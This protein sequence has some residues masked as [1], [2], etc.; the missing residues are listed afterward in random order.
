MKSWSYWPLQCPCSITS[1]QK[2]ENQRFLKCCW[3]LQKVKNFHLPNTKC[4]CWC[5]CVCFL[6]LLNSFSNHFQFYR[7]SIGNLHPEVRF[8][9]LEIYNFCKY[10]HPVITKNFVSHRSVSF[11]CFAE[12]LWEV[13]SGLSYIWDTF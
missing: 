10:S 8:Y 11:I 1:L 6:L 3:W 5:V 7:N 9:K 13:V 12:C 2:S 4:C